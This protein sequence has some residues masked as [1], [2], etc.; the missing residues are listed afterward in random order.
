MKNKIIRFVLVG[1]GRISERH[2]EILSNNYIDGIKLVAVC[3][4]NENKAKKISSKFSIPYFTEMHKMMSTI[5][6]DV[7]VILTPSGM[8]A[9][10]VIQ[11][12]K[13]KCDI[14]VEKPMALN[15][16]DA[17]LMIEA[18]QKNNVK[19]FVVKQNR[20]NK[21]ILKLREA[22]EK[23]YFGKLVLA[24]IRVRWARHQKYYDN[25][26]W[27]GTW[28]LDGGVIGNQASHH[29]DMLEWMMGDIHSVFSKTNTALADIEAE[30]TALAIIKFKNGALGIIEATTATR[31]NNLEGSISILGEKGVVVVAGIA[32]NKLETWRFE[33]KENDIITEEFNENPTDVYG[34]GHQSFYQHVLN[35]LKNNEKILVDGNEAKKSIMLVNAMYESDEKGVEILM[36]NSKGSSRLGK[37][38]DK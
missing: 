18:C 20:F 31:P 24:T 21:P 11:L 2:S 25:D 17:D 32:M 6:T 8:H 15:L 13:Y 3:D 1:C 37:K 19:L 38:N 23:K 33:D 5:E 16:E 29:I 22:I 26:S 9:D 30:D 10:N 14:I 12:S 36:E 35:C 34:F 28:L 27:R 4:I 7:I